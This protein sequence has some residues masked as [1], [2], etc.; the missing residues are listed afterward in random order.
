MTIEM[1]TLC[2]QVTSCG[3]AMND[4]NFKGKQD[5]G[6]CGRM[7]GSKSVQ[8]HDYNSPNLYYLALFAWT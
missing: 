7:L 1:F 2:W 5:I 4:I 8:N 6:V 3:N